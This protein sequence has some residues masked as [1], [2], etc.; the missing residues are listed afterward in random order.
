MNDTIWKLQWLDKTLNKW[1]TQ[2]H[3]DSQED[4]DKLVA[5]FVAACKQHG[6]SMEITEWR[7]CTDVGV[8]LPCH[9][10]LPETTC[11]LAHC[12]SMVNIATTDVNRFGHTTVLTETRKLELIGIIFRED[13]QDGK[14]VW[15]AEITCGTR[16]AITIDWKSASF[17]VMEGCDLNGISRVL[18]ATA[19]RIDAMPCLAGKPQTAHRRRSPMPNA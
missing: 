18:R 14:R 11:F 5:A 16:D 9:E 4:F 2:L 10:A 8:R 15:S 19:D 17:A 13:T 3:S 7:T 6:I 12:A 1:K